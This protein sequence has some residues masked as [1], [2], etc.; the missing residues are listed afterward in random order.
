M[1][2][3]FRKDLE[4]G[5]RF[6]EFILRWTLRRYPNAVRMEGNFKDYDIDTKSHKRRADKNHTI[7][8]KFDYKSRKT[9]NIALEYEDR[10]GNPSGI[11][12]T[13]ATL[14]AIGFFQDEWRVAFGRAE[15][16]RALCNEENKRS[17]G[18]DF[19]TLMHVIPKSLLF[20]TKGVK[21]DSIKRLKSLLD[22]E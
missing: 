10:N 6:E 17:G 12:A 11:M 3:Q 18:D 2:A 21:I 5:H 9:E 4:M 13:T 16:F 22:A 19:L 7:E 15:T 8:C 20:K 14:W 1:T